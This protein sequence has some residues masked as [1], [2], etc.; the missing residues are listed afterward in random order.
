MIT[1]KFEDCKNNLFFYEN[2]IIYHNKNVIGCH[3]GCNRVA[4]RWFL[5]SGTHY[6]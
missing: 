1:K 3:F 4:E 2:K 5:K 6:S